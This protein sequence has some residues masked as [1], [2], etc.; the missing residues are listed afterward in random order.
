MEY[1]NQFS[2]T[3]SFY[4]WC[5]ENNRIDLNDRFDEEKNGCTT[6]EVGY[7][8]N[9]KYWFKCPKGIHESEQ[10]V[11]HYVT[12]EENK[13]LTCRK[14]NSVAQVVIDKFGQDYLEC[15]WHKDNILSPWDISAGS[16]K[17]NVIVQCNKKDYHVYSQV[18]SSF[19]KGIGCPYCINRK[20][21]PNDSLA[22]I[23]PEI[24]NRWSD[25]NEKSPYEYSPHSEEKVWFKCPIGKHDDYLQKIANSVLY[26][27]RCPNCSL[28]ETSERMRG[29]GCHF[30]EGGIN[31]ENDTL[32][33]RREYRDWRTAV[34]ERDNYTCQCCGQ[35][36]GRLNAHHINQFANYP[37]LRYDI[38][39]G[40][41]L[42]TKCHDSIEDG[43]FHNIYGT[44]NTTASQLRQYILDKSDKDIFI[45]NPNLLY[46]IPLLLNNELFLTTQ[47]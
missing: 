2:V 39:N 5:V 32:R 47:N 3:K 43:S 20:V 45:T 22:S 46:Q 12:R 25:K 6:K 1:G 4:D 15:H 21:H 9:L 10:T 17:T 24:I 19:A 29:D 37:E 35:R 18:A 7:K 23:Y 44:H 34:Y 30:W 36:G 42:C 38:N 8:S 28:E 14:C 26:E 40:I 13:V 31:G 11:M 16:T 33:H 41:T 27:F